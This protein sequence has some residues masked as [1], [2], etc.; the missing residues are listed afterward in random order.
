MALAPGTCFITNDLYFARQLKLGEP[1]SLSVWLLEQWHRLKRPQRILTEFQERHIWRKI[2]KKALEKAPYQQESLLNQVQEAWRLYRIWNL[3]LLE[4]SYFLT[5]EVQQFIGWQ[6]SFIAYCEEHQVL[7]ATELIPNLLKRWEELPFSKPIAWVGSSEND[8]QTEALL[9]RL[10]TYQRF[11][12]LEPHFPSPTHVE[13]KAFL[14]EENEFHA[15]AEWAV[16]CQRFNPQATIQCIVPH[17]AEKAPLIRRAFQAVKKNASERVRVNFRIQQSLGTLPFVKVALRLLAWE[18]DKDPIPEWTHCFLS[19]YFCPSVIALNERALVVKHFNQCLAYPLN[20][21][22]F[23]PILEKETPSEFVEQLKNYI[24]ARQCYQAEENSLEDWRAIFG[25]ILST[26]GAFVPATDS[27]EK[28]YHQAWQSLLQVFSEL[29]LRATTVSYG[30]AVDLLK[31]VA[32]QY[33]FRLDETEEHAI[34][35]LDPT[36]AQNTFSDYRWLAQLQS[37]NWPGS[38]QV[39]PFL[40]QVLQASAAL[41]QGSFQSHSARMARRFKRL[42][43]STSILKLSYPLYEQEKTLAPTL[44]LKELSVTPVSILEKTFQSRA[45][46]LMPSIPPEPLKEEEFVSILT[47]ELESLSGGTSLLIF[48]QACPFKAFATYRLKVK[49]EQEVGS[50]LTPADRGILIHAIL[51]K[52]WQKLLTQ[53]A[54]KKYSEENLNNLIQSII[55]RVFRQHADKLNRLPLA[56]RE[57]EKTY[58][59][60]CVSRWLAF[61]KERPPFKVVACE[62]VLSWSIGGLTLRIKLDRIDDIAGFKVILDYKTG[63]QTVSTKDWLTDPPLDL[64]LPLYS[65]AYPETRGVAIAQCQKREPRLLGVTA[66]DMEINGLTVDEEW[67]MRV[68]RWKSLLTQIAERFLQGE[69]KVAPNHPKICEQCHLKSLC[70][71]KSKSASL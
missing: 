70:R 13:L 36:E 66:F 34:Q 43:G 9:E 63:E 21:E 32:D 46:Q 55:H 41:P 51:E 6:R 35:I 7:S 71:I 38:W 14:D 53:E 44:F 62:K 64:Q 24:L 68:Q 17:L 1:I 10:A 20:W 3:P 27:K 31:E 57:L 58:L 61:E 48:Q 26:L 11:R 40:P 8:P 19:S 29:D 49:P 15:M 56:W 59:T 22:S 67:E 52:L 12:R 30:V 2:L 28:Q 16:E 5:P 50:Y 45:E 39:N 69:T 23:L 60:R 33:L 47:E 65:V 37:E 4:K 18:P 54:L 25:E 42:T